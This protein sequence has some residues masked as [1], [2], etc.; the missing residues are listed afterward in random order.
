MKFEK[1][2]SKC[3]RIARKKGVEHLISNS[4]EDHQ[5]GYEDGNSTEDEVLLQI[6]YMD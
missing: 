5:S 6:S 1:W 3:K 2:Y 4:P